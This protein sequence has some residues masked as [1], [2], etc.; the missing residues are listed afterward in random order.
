MAGLIA[1]LKDPNS[2]G[3]QPGPNPKLRNIRPVGSKNANLD[4]AQLLQKLL[5]SA[6]EQIP[7]INGEGRT[8]PLIDAKGS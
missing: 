7:G 1:L 8:Y 3:P 5:G 6:T 2:K 4:P